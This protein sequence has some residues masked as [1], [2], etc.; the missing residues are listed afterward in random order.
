MKNKIFL[1]VCISIML[2][3]CKKKTNDVV[4]DD[5]VE[6]VE[7]DLIVSN[8][9]VQLSKESAKELESWA[10]YQMAKSIL[11]GYTSIT[12]G[13]ALENAKNLSDLVRGMKDSKYPEII[14]RDDVIIRLSVLLNHSLRLQDMRAI[15]SISDEEVEAEIRKM[16]TAYSSLNDKI[17]AVIKIE[18]YE[19]KYQ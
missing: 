11:D 1:C 6:M 3:S 15:S 18:D 12:K 16:L 13:R 8:I 10:E 19:R 17:N 14:D 7:Q 2:F 9:G 5:E 4:G